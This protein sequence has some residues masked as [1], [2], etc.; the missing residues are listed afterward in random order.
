M[1]TKFFLIGS[2]LAVSL[3]AVA[4]GSKAGSDQTS[5][6][7]TLRG[8]GAE[9]E[10]GDNVEQP[11][12]TV[13]GQIIKVN[14]MDVQVFE[15]ETAEALE[16]DV[17]QISPD[18]GSVGTSMVGWIATPHFY[19]SG[20]LIALYVGDDQA[21]LDLLEGALGAQFAGR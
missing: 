7:G 4:C 20:R 3:F 17:A 8:A 10:L 5:L 14:G 13:A 1:K 11:F 2:L 18:G 9:V 15:Y 16:A 6:V 12:F 21:T 19:K